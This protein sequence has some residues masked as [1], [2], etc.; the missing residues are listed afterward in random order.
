MRG[1]RQNQML[2]SD[3]LEGE[4]AAL[5]S[6]IAKLRAAEDEDHAAVAALAAEIETRRQ[7]LEA[8]EGRLTLARNALAEHEQRLEARRADLNAALAEEARQALKEAMSAREAAGREVAAA[9]ETLLERLAALD[10]ARER[11]HE[12]L[13]H[14]V[15]RAAGVSQPL[16]G[17]TAEEIDA[18]PEGMRDAWDRLT[19]EVR[20]RIDSRFEDELVQAAVHSPMGHA[21]QDLPVH[22]QELARQRRLAYVRTSK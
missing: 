16:D 6:Q 10:L 11:A 21:I 15:A 14:A 12:A 2:P 7:E 3:E 17:T 1:V 8:H 18:D 22:L 5:A 9:A 13:A 20:R 19:L 4:I